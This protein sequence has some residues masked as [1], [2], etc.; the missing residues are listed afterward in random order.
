MYRKE[1]VWDRETKDYACYLDGSLIGFARSYVEG[2]NLLDQ[3]VA[4]LLELGIS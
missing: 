2:E 4:E 3:K 1:I